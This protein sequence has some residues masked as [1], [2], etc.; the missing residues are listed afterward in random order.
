MVLPGSSVTE[1][2]PAVDS[3]TAPSMLRTYQRPVTFSLSARVSV[4][5]RKTAK[6]PM[7]RSSL[8]RTG[9]RLVTMTVSSMLLPVDLRFSA[10]KLHR[11]AGM[12]KALNC[13]L[14]DDLRTA[15]PGDALSRTVEER[16][17]TLPVN[18]DYPL[19]VESRIMAQV[20]KMK[21]FSCRFL[22]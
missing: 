13:G 22:F 9:S 14:A 10:A 11:E 5:S 6:A 3:I 21:Y 15:Q 7:M 20:H 1:M 2:A 16:N 8:S 4:M 19:W 12:G 17:H 18:C